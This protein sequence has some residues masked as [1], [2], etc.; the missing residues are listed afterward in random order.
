[1]KTEEEI[2]TRIEEI[3][4]KSVLIFVGLRSSY[5]S[6]RHQHI[7]LD[8]LG[9]QLRRMNETEAELLLREWT[10]TRVLALNSGCPFAGYGYESV[11]SFVMD[12]P[13][14][15]MHSEYDKRK[16]NV[17]LFTRDADLTQLMLSV[18]AILEGLIHAGLE[19]GNVELRYIQVL[20]LEEL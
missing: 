18:Q 8:W 19:N 4:D 3:C 12:L 13:A 7:D 5:D 20:D 16:R 11:E 17:F 2:V 1:M 10:E 6:V 9:A 15:A 14:I